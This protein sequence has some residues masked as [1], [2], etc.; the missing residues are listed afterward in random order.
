MLII[1]YNLLTPLSTIKFYKNVMVS[2]N[3]GTSSNKYLIC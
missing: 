2:H 1:A 3:Q